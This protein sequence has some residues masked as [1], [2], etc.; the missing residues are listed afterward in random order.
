LKTDWI[1][2]FEN[3][4]KTFHP[5]TGICRASSGVSFH[6]RK[7]EI[8]GIIGEN[9]AGKSTAMKMLYGLYRPDADGGRIRVRGKDVEYRSPQDAIRDGI[10]MVHQHFMLAGPYSVL[11]NIILGAETLG[12]DAKR[13]TFGIDRD[14]A[15]AKLTELAK[16]YGLEV[17]LDAAVET[18][19]VGVQQRIEILKALYRGCEIL[20]L[21]EPTAVLTPPEVDHLLINLRNLKAEGKTILIITHKLKEVLAFTDRVTVFRQGKVSGEVTTADA[22]VQRLADLMVGRKVH[23]HLDVPPRAPEGV[24]L[25][26]ERVSARRNGVQVLKEVSFQ[27]RAGEVVGIA[28]VEG[29]GQSELLDAL[30][31]P[32]EKGVIDAGSVRY[33]GKDATR[34]STAQILCQGIGFVPEDRHEQGL[35][36]DRSVEDNFMLGQQKQYS[37]YG[38]LRRRWIRAA[39]SR[40][41]DAFDIRP[42][43]VDEKIRGLTGGNQQKVIIAREFEKNPKILV[44]AQPT[45]GVDVGAIEFIHGRIL[46]AREDGVAVL[47][48]SSE[49]DEV[50][51]LSDRVLV[52]F[53]GR[54]VAEYTRGEADE[55]R[56]GNVMAGGTDT[57]SA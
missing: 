32:S 54:V 6:V 3:V 53:S 13:W 14:G 46:K 52:L 43:R 1:V 25:E 37:W 42:R 21:D 41:I 8:H 50:L 51:Q 9:G 15:R 17:P 4:S 39:V 26:V 34:C 35:L 36:L 40:A 12:G 29:N 47:L 2:E 19:P 27:V 45:R 10:G 11:D 48:V 22:T 57:R 24:A 38:W 30:L 49:L 20:I 44:I 18:L 33:F 55:K 5:P 7:G 56:I 23:L 28:G 31:H 16:R